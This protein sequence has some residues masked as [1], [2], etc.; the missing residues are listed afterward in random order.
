MGK[1]NV[2]RVADVGFVF[3]LAGFVFELVVGLGPVPVLLLHDTRS[4]DLLL[5]VSGWNRGD[6]RSQFRP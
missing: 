3:E 5:P 1:F 2:P 6:C 4:H